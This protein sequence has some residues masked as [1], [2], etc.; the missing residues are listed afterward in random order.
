M[1]TFPLVVSSPDGDLFHGDVIKLSL[2]GSE[3][4]LAV[5]AGHIPFVT[6]VK[7]GKI[8]IE[9]LEEDKI[10]HSDGGILSVSD[11]TVTL[12][13]GSFTWTDDPDTN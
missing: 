11:T 5:M 4:D 2:R 1:K 10:A 7:P 8:V 6:A 12:L 9:L 3:G 13:S